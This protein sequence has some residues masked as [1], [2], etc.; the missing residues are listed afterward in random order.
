MKK[1]FN[2]LN[3]FFSDEAI[4]YLQTKK[5]KK[6]KKPYCNTKL[7]SKW[8]I[9][10]HTTLKLQNFQKI[11]KEFFGSQGYVASSETYYHKHNSKKKKGKTDKLD[12]I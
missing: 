12:I 8:I 11:H 6:Q 4:E 9:N 2:K 10:L 1:Q 5:K 7:N 3:Y